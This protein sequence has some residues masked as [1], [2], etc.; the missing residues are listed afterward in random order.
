[1]LAG[2]APA[3]PKVTN[4]VVESIRILTVARNSAVKA[5]SIAMSQLQDILV[6]APAQLREQI[7]VPGTRRKAALCRNFRPDLSRLSDPVQAAK[8]TLK[9]LAQRI[10][11]LDAE[12][13]AI[14]A[15]LEEL[16][17]VTAPTLVS[18]VGIGT[19]HAAQ[20]LITAGRNIDRLRSEASFARLCGAAPI[21]VSSGAVTGCG[22]IAVATAK[23][24]EPC[25]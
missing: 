5:R 9:S 1:M 13:S 7:S 21:P 12:V 22:Y 14:D 15:H 10:E 8:L 18:R 4:G 2:D 19:G 20:F 24:T 11:Q 6:T 17:S 16:V 3:V 23:P 25:I